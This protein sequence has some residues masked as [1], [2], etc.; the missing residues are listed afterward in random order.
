[1]HLHEDTR[2]MLKEKFKELNLF[3]SNGKFNSRVKLPSKLIETCFKV[4]RGCKSPKLKDRIYWILH[5]IHNYANCVVCEK[6]IIKQIRNFGDTFKHH[7]H[8]SSSCR[9]KD[10]E[11]AAGIISRRLEQTGYAYPMQNPAVRA[12]AYNTCLKKYGAENPMQNTELFQKFINARYKIKEFVAP[13]GTVFKYQGFEDVALRSLLSNEQIKP[14]DIATGKGAVPAI[15][16]YNNEKQRKSKYYPDIY[17]KSANTLIE[18]KSVYTFTLNM[19]ETLDKQAACKLLGYEHIILI[20]SK[21]KIL[22]IL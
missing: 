10:K 4:T 1:M 12:K 15:Y 16:Y 13:D 5:D 11:K 7:K 21:S 18:V 14:S 3:M 6:P 8:C 22:N 20:C 19:Q 9:F 17:V 2:T